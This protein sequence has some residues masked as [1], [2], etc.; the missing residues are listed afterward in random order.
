VLL[1]AHDVAVAIGR[2]QIIAGE[3]VTCP[4]GAMT[5]LVGPSGSGK[6]TLLHALGLLLPV[7]AGSIT[8]DGRTV[9]GGSPRARRRFWRER[10]AFVLQDYGIIDEESVGFNVVLTG[11]AFRRGDASR[12]M[13]QALERVGLGGRAPEPAGHLSG[14]EQQRLALARAIYRRAQVL[15]VDEPTASLDAANR[16]HVIALFTE[17]A[18]GGATVVVSTHDEDLIAACDLQHRMRPSA[19]TAD[20]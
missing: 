18:R 11:R 4:P 16:E 19:V 7:S 8:A 13:E 17:L 14:G 15:L 1:E 2:R 20:V 6:T 12:R 9:S 10:A 5:A 3:T